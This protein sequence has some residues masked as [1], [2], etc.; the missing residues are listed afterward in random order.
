MRM[1]ISVATTLTEFLKTRKAIAFVTLLGIFAF[2]MS[3]VGR[4]SYFLEQ[5]PK[6]VLMKKKHTWRSSTSLTIL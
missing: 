3:E 6:S 4:A 5:S 2:V 1:Q